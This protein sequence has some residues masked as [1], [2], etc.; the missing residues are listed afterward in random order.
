MNRAQTIVQHMHRI[1]VYIYV[2]VKNKENQN[3]INDSFSCY[4]LQTYT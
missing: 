4:E 3:I 2:P 1:L